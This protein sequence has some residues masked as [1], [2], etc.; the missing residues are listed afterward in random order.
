MKRFA[1]LG[2]IAVLAIGLLI[3]P[4]LA[5]EMSVEAI[6]K[7]HVKALGG[8]EAIDK[9]KTVKRTGT[10]SMDGIL[11]QM[12]GTTEEIF[13]VGKK[14]YQHTDYE[15]YMETSGWNGETGWTKNSMEALKDVTG[16]DL[17][18]L[19][20]AAE[21]SFL[22]TIWQEYGNVALER[23]PDESYE[24]V[25]Y[26]VLQIIGTEINCYLDPTTK[27]I[28]AMDMP[29]EDPDLGESELLIV[30]EDYNAH[31]GVM[32]PDS[33]TILIGEDL[34]VIENKY[35][36]TRINEPVDDAIFEKPKN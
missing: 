21:I 2:I 28:A 29:F 11:G 26:I 7:A 15:M 16:E 27:L 14:S 31:N 24:G 1:L 9:I 34:L 35:T 32:L 6:M 23:L 4:S 3:G 36:E 12:K 20:S 5:E 18:D 22:A 17:E 8:T 13:V 33:M 10:S 25:D 19:E 30:T